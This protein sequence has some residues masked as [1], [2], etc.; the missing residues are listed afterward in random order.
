MALKQRDES[1][2]YLKIKGG[3]FYVGK[4]LDTP[5]NELEGTIVGLRYKDEEYE[6]VPQRKFLITLQDNGEKYQLN[7]N[8]ESST[9]GAVVSF[10]A[11]VDVSKKLTLHPKETVEAKDGKDVARRTMLVSQEGK[12][13]KNYFNKED[14]HGLPEWNIV[15]VGKKKVVDKS[16]YLEFLENFVAEK[17]IPNL[18]KEV[19]AV[20]ATAQAVAVKP[21][22]AISKAAPVVDTSG[23]EFDS[24]PVSTTGLPWD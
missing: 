13:A 3:K 14:R 20:E 15:M 12:F 21:A 10:L 23:D 2:N 22:S 18:S 4:D 5:Y 24:D 1:M 9:Y 6:G 17:L 7:M 16:A 19:T 8:V 11:N